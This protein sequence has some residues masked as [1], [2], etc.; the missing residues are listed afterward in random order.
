MLFY[1]LLTYFLYDQC[2]QSAK[3]Q[4]AKLH[5]CMTAQSSQLGGPQGLQATIAI[6]KYNHRAID[7]NCLF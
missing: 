3:L 5:A 6:N 4:S 1:S 2:M 7:T